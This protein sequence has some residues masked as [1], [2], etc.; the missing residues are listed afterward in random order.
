MSPK[1]TPRTGAT[2]VLAWNIR[3]GGGASLGG[4]IDALARHDADIV[5]LCEY[6]RTTGPALRAGLASL[7]YR[8]ATAVE[9]PPGRNGVLIA[10]R[11]PLRQRG[12]FSA[13][14]PEPHRMLD[15]DVA[16]LRLTGV[17]MPNLLRKVPYWDAVL[18]AAVR[19]RERPALFVG[20]FNTTRHYLDEAGA[21]CLTSAYMDQI[22]RAGFRDVFRHRHPEAREFSWYS[23][24]GNGFRLDHAFGSERASAGVVAVDYSHGERQAGL[25]DHSALVIDLEV[26]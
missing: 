19:R 7:G 1:V 25:S 4:I 23:T 6:R 17:Y 13:R 3:H 8:Y 14:V 20:D 12:A 11:R 21:M 10:A 2:R 9:P 18:R 22:E 16:G 15:V 5:V 26:T 24:R